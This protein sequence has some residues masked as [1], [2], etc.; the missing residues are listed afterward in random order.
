MNPHAIAADY[1]SF[2]FFYA[3][4]FVIACA[5]LIHEGRRRHWPLVAW[6]GLIAWGM[7]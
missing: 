6:L 5:I 7:L 1:G 4:A 2:S 3:L